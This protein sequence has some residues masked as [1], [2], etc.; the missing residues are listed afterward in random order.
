[1]WVVDSRY[2]EVDGTSRICHKWHDRNNLKYRTYEGWLLFLCIQICY[3]NED[4]VREDGRIV[5]GEEWQEGVCNREEC[6]RLLRTAK[7]RCILHVPMK[8]NSS[9][10]LFNAF[11]MPCQCHPPVLYC[12][13]NIQWRV[14]IVT[15]Q[16]MLLLL[17]ELSTGVITLSTTMLTLSL[18]NVVQ[19]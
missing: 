17:A 15:F 6:K 2:G 9:P 4:E 8:K 10:Y 18:Y 5:G 11:Y 16:T 3:Q 1:M 7:N 19:Y 13:N 14:Q 12:L